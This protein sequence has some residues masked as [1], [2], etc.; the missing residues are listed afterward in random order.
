MIQKYRKKQFTF[1]FLG[2]PVE[3]TQDGLIGSGII[4]LGLTIAAVFLTELTPLDALIAGF[5]GIFVHWLFECLHQYGHYL[6]GRF[7]GY[8][9]QK[10]KTWWVL[11][12]SVYP[13]DEPELAPA[14]HLRRAIAGPIFSGAISIVLLAIAPTMWGIGGMIRFLIG[15]ALFF[16]IG[17]MTVGALVPF[18]LGSFS[19]DGA[20]ILKY[21]RQRNEA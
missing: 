2:V 7:V 18:E 13:R 12:P 4:W 5:L 19:T 20:T 16:N 6:G 8:P 14:I 11:A 9:L 15:Y 17:V 21:I 1:N 3:F 10:M